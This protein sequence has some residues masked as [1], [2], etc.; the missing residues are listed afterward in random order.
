[1]YGICVLVYVNLLYPYYFIPRITVV[2]VHAAQIYIIKKLHFISSETQI[3]ATFQTIFHF[4]QTQ[5][6][7][8]DKRQ[9]KYVQASKHNTTT[10]SRSPDCYKLLDLCQSLFQTSA[11]PCFRPP[12][13]TCNPATMQLQGT[14]S[15]PSKLEG[16]LTSRRT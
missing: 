16:N 3:Q 9:N 8:D 6:Q 13:E 2:W 7:H 15:I 14:M 11:S 1:M 10:H 4:I 5:I 12:K